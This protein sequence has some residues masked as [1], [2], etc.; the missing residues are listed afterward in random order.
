MFK[1]ENSEGY[2]DSEILTKLVV[3]LKA[4]LKY[5]LLQFDLT[6]DSSSV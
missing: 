3:K 2:G 4:N 1:R 5:F 6:S